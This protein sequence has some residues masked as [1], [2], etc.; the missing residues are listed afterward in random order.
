[1]S[2]QEFF[3]GAPIRNFRSARTEI[4]CHNSLF[5]QTGARRCRGPRCMAPIAPVLKAPLKIKNHRVPTAADVR[6]DHLAVINTRYCS[7]TKCAVL[8]I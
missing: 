2:V 4:K 6:H 7:S 8:K 1:M 3:A 5:A